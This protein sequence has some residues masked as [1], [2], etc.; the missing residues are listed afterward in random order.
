VNRIN[1][2]SSLSRADLQ[3]IL[4]RGAS[5]TVQFSKPTYSPKLLKEVNGFCQ[6]YG[7]N[8]EVRFYGH[9]SGAFDASALRFLPDVQ[10]LSID[11]LQRIENDEEVFR[12]ENLRK[13][14]FGVY[15]YD[16][17]DLLA[18][19]KIDG[20]LRLV[21][22]DNDKRNFDLE[23]LEECS[24]LEEFYLNGHTKNIGVLSKLPCLRFLSL[25]SISKKTRLEFA[26]GIQQLN[27]L[28][29]ILGGREAID[30]VRHESLRE[31][32]IVRVKAFESLGDMSRFP[33]L[34]KLVVEDQIRLNTIDL[35]GT[36]LREVSVHNCKNL[37]EID[38]L[39]D[40]SD[41]RLF[42]TSRTKLDLELLLRAD[43]PKS[44]EVVGLFST[45]DRWNEKAREK[46]AERGYRQFDT[47]PPG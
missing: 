16:R 45:S 3:N 32:R 5:P 38:G 28:T 22:A 29:I 46:L 7:S 10:W 17:S 18:R 39:L 37:S 35:R 12:L 25:G 20:L 8:L 36:D 42:A 4:S 21:L 33:K 31:L 6:E 24:E 14:S 26:S 15:Y 1:D 19:I 43:W 44:M 47:P 41:L 27:S 34:R 2:P 9:Y 40:L 30:E 13:F 23:P 11:C